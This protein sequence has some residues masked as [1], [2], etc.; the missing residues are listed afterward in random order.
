MGK[1]EKVHCIILYC[2]YSETFYSFINDKTA[3]TKRAYNFEVQNRATADT[4]RE[5]HKFLKVCCAIDGSS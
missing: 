2:V 4:L 5:N 3:I 1:S